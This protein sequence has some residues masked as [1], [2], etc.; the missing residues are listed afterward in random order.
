MTTSAPKNTKSFWNSLFVAA[1]LLFS[2]NAMGVVASFI[3]IEGTLLQTLHTYPLRLLLERSIYHNWKEP[4]ELS[5]YVISLLF[6]VLIF[7]LFD[8]F[9]R[10]GIGRS[11]AGRITFLLVLYFVYLGLHFL[12]ALVYIAIAT[13]LR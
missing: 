5:L 1:T 10:L 9:L 6:S 8:H 2:L 12:F 11:L 13:I 3:T 4:K 7:A